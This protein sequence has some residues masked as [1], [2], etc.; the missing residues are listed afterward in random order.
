MSGYDFEYPFEKNIRQWNRAIEIVNFKTCLQLLRCFG[1]FIE[2]LE[3]AYNNP[4]SKRDQY[5]HR[6]VNNYCAETLARITFH[7][8]KNVDIAEFQKVF[9]NIKRVG[10]WSC[11]LGNQWPSFVN[12]FPNLSHLSFAF[13]KFDGSSVHIDYRL[14]EKPFPNL[15]YL[16]FENV[17]GNRSARIKFL[18]DLLAGTSQLKTLVIR[19][20]FYDLEDYVP[21]TEYLDLIKDHSSITEIRY[22]N[23]Y[24]SA[25]SAEIQR[26]INEHPALVELNMGQ[27]IVTP[28]DVIALT[29][30]LGSLKKFTFGTDINHS[31]TEWSD[32]KSKI[33][34]EWELN[35][36]DFGRADLI[37]RK[38]QN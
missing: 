18:G 28:N 11:D 1:P 17:R 3:I 8:L 7:A 6:Y 36:S 23:G 26:I 2:D 38:E 20:I 27:T 29:R 32:L 37:R 25:T 21:I 16:Y 22:S 31:C 12:L 5:V 13:G 4:E 30:Q 24:E 19:D 9:V 33:R 10:F 35:Y 14:V 15:E 34:N